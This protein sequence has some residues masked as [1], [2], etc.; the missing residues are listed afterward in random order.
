MVLVNETLVY[1]ALVYASHIKV[2]EEY[3]NQ[4]RFCSN[5]FDS[6]FGHKSARNKC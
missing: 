5:K 4:F 1:I 6:W 3:N 2:G